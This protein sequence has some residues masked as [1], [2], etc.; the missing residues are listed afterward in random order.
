MSSFSD[1]FGS[2]L[3]VVWRTLASQC[4]D[5]YFSWGVG[6]AK[7]LWGLKIERNGR[8]HQLYTPP[9]TNGC[10]PKMEVWKMIFIFNWV[11]CRFHVSFRGGII[12]VYIYW[13]RCWREHDCIVSK[14]SP[15]QWWFCFKIK[16]PVS[17][18][19]NNMQKPGPEPLSLSFL[20]VLLLLL[21]LLQVL[22]F[23]D[24]FLLLVDPNPAIQFLELEKHD[25][26]KIAESSVWSN[27]SDLTRPGP[28][29]C[30]WGREIPSFQGNLVWWNMIIWP[31]Q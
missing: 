27:Y 9:K 17:I 21:L 16:F 4:R 23:S 24:V 1:F 2:K 15:E 14:T 18:L 5:W 25:R 6:Q 13:T 19:D 8:G 7:I 12:Y 30:S 28:R 31:D 20:L 29:K 11:I 10:N 22:F 3:L 26:R